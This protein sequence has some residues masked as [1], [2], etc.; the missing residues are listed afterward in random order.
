MPRASKLTE[1]VGGFRKHPVHRLCI[2]VRGGVRDAHERYAFSSRVVVSLPCQGQQGTE[3]T[4][5]ADFPP[6][7]K[8]GIMHLAS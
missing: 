7:M 4:V 3:S 2:Q 8:Y 6:K 1:I 5:R